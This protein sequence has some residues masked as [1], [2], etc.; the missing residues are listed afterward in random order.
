ML[1]NTGRWRN[2]MFKEK[3]VRI[4][5][6]DEAHFINKIL[7]IGA[8]KQGEF[9][10]RRYVYDFNPI[11]PNKLIRLRTNGNK[12]TLTI[13]EIKD[14]Y[15]IDGTEEL[16][17]EVDDFD[18]TNFILNQLGYK[19]RNYQENYRKVFVL[20]NTEI[21]IDSWPLIPTYVEIEGK[22]NNDVINTLTKIGY[23]LTDVTTLDVESIYREI[24]GINIKEIK[25]LKF[26]DDSY[27]SMLEYNKQM[28]QK[29]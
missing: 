13:K 25:E 4:L 17:V 16:E 10:Q 26:G 23:S 9:F 15:A 29:L 18:N 8:I 11:N 6:I 2:I 19:A 3:E 14:R 21:S 1:Y 24:Y 7:N 28:Q 22:N 20:D 5:E 27:E 12:T